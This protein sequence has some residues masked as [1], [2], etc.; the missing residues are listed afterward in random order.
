MFGHGHVNTGLC[1]LL[2]TCAL[3]STISGRNATC[4]VRPAANCKHNDLEPHPEGIYVNA[5]DECC[6]ACE[7]NATCKAWTVDKRKADGD[8]IG[9]CY[10]KANCDGLQMD[11]EAVSGVMSDGAPFPFAPCQFPD[12]SW[13]QCYHATFPGMCEAL[14]YPDCCHWC[15]SSATGSCYA[16][17]TA[18]RRPGSASSG[19]ILDGSAMMEKEMKELLGGVDQHKN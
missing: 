16:N 6:K 8:Y 19:E 13:V 2:T 18:C 12:K 5:P 9:R 3:I 7:G 17:R 1:W 11:S 4:E 14:D 10:L 15:G